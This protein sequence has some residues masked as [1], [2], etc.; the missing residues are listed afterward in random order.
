MKH[1]PK[2]ER[3]PQPVDIE[4]AEGVRVAKLIAEK[5][6]SPTAA[7]RH[8]VIEPGGNTPWHAHDWEHVIYVL[9]GE[10]ALVTDGKVTPFSAG[11]ALLVEP[12]EE[13]NFVNRGSEPVRFLCV[14]PLRGD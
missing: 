1:I 2:G 8:F 4:G 5:D 3:S 11:D 12:D 7:M 13:H 10:G 6:E 14:V 9:E